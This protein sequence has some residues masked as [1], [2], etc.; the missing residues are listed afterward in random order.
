MR[1]TRSQHSGAPGYRLAECAGHNRAVVQHLYGRDD[2]ESAVRSRDNGLVIVAGDSGIGKTRFLANL[3]DGWNDGDLVAAPIT[4]GAVR[5]SLQGA[6]ADA[7]GDCLHQ[8]TVLNPEAARALWTTIKTAAVQLADAT[9]RQAG[10]LLVSRAFEFL[11]SKIG[12]EAAGAVRAVL[13]EVLRPASANYEQRLEAFVVPDTAADLTH[14][15]RELAKHTGRRLVLLL[16]AGERLAAD[17]RSLLTELATSLEGVPVLIV[18][19]VNSSTAEGAELVRTTEGRDAYCHRIGALDRRSIYE[20]LAAEDVPRSSW[21]AIVHTSSGYPLFIADALRLV[22]GG[23]SLA[24][25]QSPV[26]FEA[27]FRASWQALEPGL[28]LI[29]TQLA[30]FADPPS[31]EFLCA[32]LNRNRLE[33][34]TLRKRLVASGVFVSRA[35]GDEWFHERR[36]QY[37]WNTLLTNDDR[38]IVSGEVLSAI[39]SWTSS[40]NE[41]EG[42]IPGAIP[43]AVRQVPPTERGSYVDNLLSL[44]RYELGILWALL[45]V[46]EPSGKQGQFSET[47]EVVR[48]AAIRAGFRGDPV[49][50]IE[51]LVELEMA[52]IA[53][54]QH[55]SIIC[56]IVPDAFAH[57]A[58]IGEIERT[59]EVAPIP[60]FASSAFEA[61]VRH[62]LVPFETAVISLGAGSLA[63]HRNAMAELSGTA[64]APRSLSQTPGLGVDIEA[65]GHPVTI[66]VA[67]ETKEHRDAARGRLSQRLAFARVG[68]VTLRGMTNLPPTRSRHRRYRNLLI[69]LNLERSVV[70]TPEITALVEGCQQTAECFSIFRKYISDEDASALGLMEPLRYL[71]DGS[72]WPTSSAEFLVAGSGQRESALV[73]FTGEAASAFDPLLEL[74]LRAQGILEPQERIVLST[75]RSGAHHEMAH[76]LRKAVERVEERGRAFNRDLPRIEVSL[77]ETELADRIFQERSV[78]TELTREIVDASIV[79]DPPDSR[80]SLVVAVSEPEGEHVW[81]RFGATCFE[82]ADGSDRVDVRVLPRGTPNYRGGYRS[83]YLQ[84][85][86]FDYADSLISAV[87]DGEATS[88]IGPLLGYDREDVRLTPR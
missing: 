18:V 85:L 64:E 55:T 69:T 48:Y 32:Y 44:T 1:R 50:A 10:Q 53:G 70:S 36:R 5:G 46:T 58:L 78:V 80:G 19:C 14:I 63:N 33:W 29:V 8:Y 65:D 45:E 40:S 37:V 35:D 71:V 31:D 67:F 25:I 30:A 73:E 82:I 79:A 43:S 7:I 9:G 66:T 86:G 74:R 76:P 72:G 34:S 75:L 39:R 61:F 84:W 49:T 24:A 11:E 83:G 81:Y 23:A 15:A 13:S 20:W 12:K 51:R 6:L 62:N 27:L 77:D 17:D 59:F 22:Q 88:I 68:H 41:I 4:L 16:D 28:Q 57:A 56:P 38:N 2:D 3:A 54:N 26:R 87:S 42:W 47:R 60:R 21:D 52:Y